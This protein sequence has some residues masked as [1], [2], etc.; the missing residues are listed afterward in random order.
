MSRENLCIRCALQITGD[1]LKG[2]CFDCL[3]AE[4][5][6]SRRRAPPLPVTDGV[7][8]LLEEIA[9]TVVYAPEGGHEEVAECVR[10]ARAALATRAA[11]PL[12]E[13]PWKGMESAPTGKIGK[14]GMRS[15]PDYIEPP[16]LLLLL[17]GG[18][19]D[20]GFYDVYYLHGFGDGANGGSCWVGKEGQLSVDPIG[21]MYLPPLPAAP[22]SQK[23]GED[24]R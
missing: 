3:K 5:E 11:P 13:S 1:S 7:W 18:E 19:Y 10:L 6:L 22:E 24:V 4:L 23:G 20:I 21:W 9:A 17:E 16:T 14:N 2:V 12:P 8:G 15:D